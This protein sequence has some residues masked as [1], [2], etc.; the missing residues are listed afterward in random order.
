MYTII[1]LH[2]IKRDS[3]NVLFTKSSEIYQEY[4]DYCDANSPAPVSI[5]DSSQFEA[6]EGQYNGKKVMFGKLS[7]AGIIKRASN[8]AVNK[9]RKRGLLISELCK[10]VHEYIT[11]KNDSSGMTTGEVDTFISAYGSILEPLSQ[12]RHIAAKELIDTITPSVYVSQEDLDAIQDMYDAY[13]PKI[14][15]II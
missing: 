7:S 13:L 4:V 9:K 12:N 6:V 10:S 3:D 5:A 8:L 11:G 1:D 2:W 15:E 14:N